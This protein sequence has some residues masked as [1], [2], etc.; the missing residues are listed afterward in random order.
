VQEDGSTVYMTPQLKHRVY[1]PASA[2]APHDGSASSQHGAGSEYDRPGSV[3]H[4][5]LS[6]LTAACYSVGHFLNDATASCWFSYLLLYLTQ[7][8]GLSAPQAGIV[9]FSGCVPLL[10]RPGR[11]AAAV[12][13]QQAGVRRPMPSERAMH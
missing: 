8:Q 1:V 13:D 11:V 10:K 9:M 12:G 3:A 2:A 5:P 6:R 7:A 4:A